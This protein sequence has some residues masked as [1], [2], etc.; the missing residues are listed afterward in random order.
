M[1]AAT[2][3]PAFNFGLTLLFFRP[4]VGSEVAVVLS[5]DAKHGVARRGGGGKSRH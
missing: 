1:T 4:F 2:G 3:E 5:V